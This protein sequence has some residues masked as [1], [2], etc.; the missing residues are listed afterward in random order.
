MDEIH[1]RP[2]G[3]YPWDDMA[4]VFVCGNGG[5]LYASDWQGEPLNFHPELQALARISENGKAV[6]IP[7]VLRSL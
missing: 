6:T 4:P 2:T 3:G 5:Q 1:Q 7:V